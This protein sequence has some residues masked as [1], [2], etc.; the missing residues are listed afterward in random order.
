MRQ[1]IK[2]MFS[3][4]QTRRPL[5]CLLFPSFFYACQLVDEFIHGHDNAYL[6]GWRETHHW[7]C[8]IILTQTKCYKIFI[9]EGALKQLVTW[10]PTAAGHSW[11]TVTWVTAPTSWI[12]LRSDISISTMYSTCMEHHMKRKNYNNLTGSR[13]IFPLSTPRF[14]GITVHTQ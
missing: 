7:S 9:E 8:E 2:Q 1:G 3:S 5:P 12:V 4:K 13:P 11:V 6:L 14:Y 10:P